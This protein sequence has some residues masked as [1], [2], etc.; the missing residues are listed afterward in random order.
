MAG[1]V[2]V[3]ILVAVVV[4]MVTR[5]K[6][7]ES[8]GP[9]L[10]VTGEKIVKST[11]VSE[12]AYRKLEYNATPTSTGPT[13]FRGWNIDFTVTVKT[14]GG[15]KEAGITAIKIVRHKVTTT[16]DSS[17]VETDTVGDA[18]DTQYIDDITNYGTFTADFP[19][20]ALSDDAVGT[21]GGKNMFKLYGVETMDDVNTT[22]DEEVLYT[23]PGTGTDGVVLASTVQTIPEAD[24]NYTL[25]NASKVAFTFNLGSSSGSTLPNIE[26]SI[27][28]TKYRISI[29]PSEIYS[30]V[31][32]TDSSGVVVANKYK[33]KKE[34]ETFLTV[35]P[36]DAPTDVFKID[37]SYGKGIYRAYTD[38]SKILTRENGTGDLALKLP[39]E[40]SKEE[41]ETSLMTFVAVY[42]PIPG[43]YTN[44]Q[45][46]VARYTVAPLDTDAC[47]AKALEARKTNSTIYGY[48]V[49]TGTTGNCFMYG[50]NISGGSTVT[51]DSVSNHKFGCIDETMNPENYCRPESCKNIPYNT[52]RKDVPLACG[53]DVY[54]QFGC[55]PEKSDVFPTNRSTSG[56]LNGGNDSAKNMAFATAIPDMKAWALNHKC[57]SDNSA[58]IPYE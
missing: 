26:S 6:K 51:A 39:T 14:K 36:T 57:N 34:D 5:D 18:L 3:I 20:S 11:T 19:G 48:G 13:D 10:E 47:R 55:T 52:A 46:S 16:T 41:S 45:L 15:F 37:M 1:I 54:R 22:D 8:T 12:Y 32:A 35:G 24:L 7:P 29:D 21:G 9:Q 25:D 27:I 4:W 33:F 40:M 23:G 43:I 53:Q 44:G 2:L 49:S 58:T 50:G 17:G 56:W 42:T 30:L 28:R 38:G 31:P